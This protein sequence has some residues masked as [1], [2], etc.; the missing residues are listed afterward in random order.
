MIVNEN[1]APMMH[2]EVSNW[3]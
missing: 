3:K 1:K 2:Q